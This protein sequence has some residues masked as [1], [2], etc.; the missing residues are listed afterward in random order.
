[1]HKP[2]AWGRHRADYSTTIFG[3]P[4]GAAWGWR[5]EGHHLSVNVTVVDGGVS[6]APLFLGANPA[7]L[8]A[9]PGSPFVTAPLDE[10]D[11]LGAA[12]ALHVPGVRIAGAVPDDILTENASQLLELPPAEGTRV[13]E[14]DE[15]GRD[16]VAR[17][18]RTYL[19]RLPPPEAREWWARIETSLGD[20]RVAYAGAPAPHAAAYYRVQG[21]HLL[22]EYDNTQNDANHIHTV[23]RDPERDFGDDAL[24]RHRA[25]HAHEGTC[26]G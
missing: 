24:R 18:I 13:A 14:M 20:V 5:F 12:V 25:E 19:E 15:P 10:E 11:V 21:P 6:I 26:T 17:L 7:R 9:R 8:A 4:S 23:L 3:D 16:L 2:E 1:R 22:I